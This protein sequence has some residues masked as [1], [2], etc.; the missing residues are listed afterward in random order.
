MDWRGESP[1]VGWQEEGS[2]TRLDFKQDSPTLE[3]VAW[4]WKEMKWNDFE[5]FVLGELKNMFS[6]ADLVPNRN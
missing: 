2:S 1:E 3:L 4:E 5:A 6:W